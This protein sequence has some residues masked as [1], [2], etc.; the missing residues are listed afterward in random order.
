MNVDINYCAT[1]KSASAP[2]PARFS[3]RSGR[4][5]RLPMSAAAIRECCLALHLQRAARAVTRSFDHALGDVDLSSGQYTVLVALAHGERIALASLA[6]ELAMDRTT[7][8]SNLKPL[9][10]RALVED[11]AVPGS[12][13]RHVILTAAGHELLAR[14]IPRWREVQRTLEARLSAPAS[15][16]ADLRRLA[17]P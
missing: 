7:L 12:R 4:S 6:A 11:I 9:S 3:T 10:R 5:A 2:S 13:L 8:I 14:A 16:Y 17:T 15:T 1:M